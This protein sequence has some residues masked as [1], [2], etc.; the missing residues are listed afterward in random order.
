MASKDGKNIYVAEGD[1]AQLGPNTYLRNP[2]TGDLT[3][4]QPTGYTAVGYLFGC[5]DDS[6]VYMLPW[7]G[8]M[9]GIYSWDRDP[10]T[11]NLPEDGQEEFLS[12]RGERYYV[13]SCTPDGK[14]VITSNWVTV[15]VWDRDADDYSL[16]HRYHFVD[17][18][19]SLEDNPFVF[20]LMI[21][22]TGDAAIVVSALA[23]VV[24]VYTRNA[25]TGEVNYLTTVDIM[26]EV[27]VV[28]NVAFLP[29]DG[30]RNVF[31]LATSDGVLSVE[32]CPGIACS[33]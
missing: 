13:A 32:P 15:G 30:E 4:G 16:T 18:V 33:F 11:G 29:V 20:H 7:S 9:D 26:P 12:R 14:Q 1:W 25:A 8:D 5:S 21:S 17:P 23:N 22:P 31:F 3:P 24:S 10:A 27:E 6:V 19:V 2:E 28:G